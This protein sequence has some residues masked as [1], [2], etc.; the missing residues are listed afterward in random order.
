MKIRTYYQHLLRINESELPL[1][2]P[3][4]PAQSLPEDEIVDILIYATPKS[5]MREM[6]RQGFDPISK[7][8]IQV[9]DFQERIEQSED[10]DGQV[11]DRSQKSN[12]SSHS[13]GK[14]KART[15]DSHGSKFC[16]KHGKCGHTSDECTVLKRLAEGSDKGSSSGNGKYGNKTW[17]R[18]AD[19]AKKSSKKELAA[20]VKKAVADKVKK[21]LNSIDK[22]RKSDDDSFDLN[23]FDGDLEGFNYKDMERLSID[24]DSDGEVSV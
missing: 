7:T 14:K 15:N 9:V 20:F 3:F 13:K 8:P 12:S 6:D 19:E 10:F 4:N 22:K 21:E 16:L 23:A 1:L 18:K 24:D 2:P 11:V 17:S 5:W